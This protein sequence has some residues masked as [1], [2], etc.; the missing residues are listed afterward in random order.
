MEYLFGAPIFFIKFMDKG[1]HLTTFYRP[2]RF[3]E[4]KGQDHIKKSAHPYCQKRFSGKGLFIQ[5][6]KGGR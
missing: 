5:W 1:K 2:Q 4:L 6:H 3:S